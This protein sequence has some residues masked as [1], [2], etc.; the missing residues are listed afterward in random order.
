L[1]EANSELAKGAVASSSRSSSAT[2]ESRLETSWGLTQ[3]V[4]LSPGYASNASRVILRSARERGIPRRSLPLGGS[5]TPDEK[6]G[7]AGILDELA[8]GP[9]SAYISP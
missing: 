8:T 5:Y 2:L 4:P 7:S 6:G 1:E 9:D 3:K